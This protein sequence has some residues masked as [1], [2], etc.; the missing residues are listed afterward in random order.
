[1]PAYIPPALR[2][3]A[4]QQADGQPRLGERIWRVTLEYSSGGPFDV[5]ECPENLSLAAESDQSADVIV[6]HFEL[7]SEAS[8]TELRELLN[9][10]SKASA[11]VS[12]RYP[13]GDTRCQLLFPPTLSKDARKHIH[14]LAQTLRLPTFSKGLGE[15]RRLMVHGVGF[16]D[17]PEMEAEVAAVVARKKAPAT[18]RD[19]ARQIWRWCQAD[20]GA[21]WSLSQGELEETL[22]AA[23]DES[24]LPPAVKDLLE[25]REHGAALIAAIRAG[26]N[27]AALAVLEAHP[28]AAWIRDDGPGG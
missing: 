26:D 10:F 19:R 7:P 16:R 1:M 22:L 6:R 12:E 15:D 8:T 18:I 11:A 2:G 3:V 20:G 23:P 28:R 5:T 9:W 25:R 21:L 27:P 13:N 14:Q 4:G 17:T 24:A